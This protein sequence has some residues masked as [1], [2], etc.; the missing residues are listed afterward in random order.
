LGSTEWLEGVPPDVASRLKASSDPRT[1]QLGSRLIVPRDT[2]CQIKPAQEEVASSAEAWYGLFRHT[3]GVPEGPAELV[4]EKALPQKANLDFL[5]F[6]NFEKGCYTGQELT[7]RTHHRGKVRRRLGIFRLNEKD[8]ATT[9]KWS[10]S[11]G[12]PR[13]TMDDVRMDSDELTDSAAADTGLETR[14]GNL[15]LAAVVQDEGMHSRSDAAACFRVA[16]KEAFTLGSHEWSLF[17][18]PFFFDQ[19]PD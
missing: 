13:L 7:I 8:D 16:Q 14:V 19:T 17:T 11:D 18:P 6:I 5:N 12:T 2:Y 15:A 4:P 3:I 9:L 10:N 1:S